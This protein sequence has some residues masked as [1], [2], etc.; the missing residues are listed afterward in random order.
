MLGQSS[1]STKALLAMAQSMPPKS[2]L[3]YQSNVAIAVE[4]QVISCPGRDMQIEWA[5]PGIRR[6]KGT[7]CC[8][9]R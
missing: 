1:I 8:M 4:A 9:A 5:K 2:R 7:C 6:S 3:G